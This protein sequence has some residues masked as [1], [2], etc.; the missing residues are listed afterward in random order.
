MNR[1]AIDRILGSFY[2]NQSRHGKLH[3]LRYT[4]EILAL[5]TPKELVAEEMYAKLVVAAV[6]LDKS[7]I[8]LKS[9]GYTVQTTANN[10]TYREIV[11][12]LAL[13]K[14]REKS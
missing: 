13:T 11:G 1:E 3:T 10:K 12:L 4:N 9:K 7:S 8:I 14:A 5:Q 6:D 2:M